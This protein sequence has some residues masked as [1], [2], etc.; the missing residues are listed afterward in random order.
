VNKKLELTRRL[1]TA[2]LA[3]SPAIAQPVAPQAAPQ[4]T[5][6][7]GAAPAGP[8]RRPQPPEPLFIASELDDR[9]RAI[10]LHQ[11][12][13]FPEEPR[14]AVTVTKAPASSWTLRLRIP[15]WSSA[16]AVK[17]NGRVLDATP[18]A[19]SYLC[20]A[21]VWKKGDRVELEMPMSLAAEPFADEP[22]VQAFLY[23]PVVLAGDFGNQGLTD[24]LVN[25]QQGPAVAK[26]PM[27]VPVSQLLRRGD[28]KVFKKY[29]QM[30]LQMKR[31]ALTKLNRKAN[32]KG[33]SG[34]G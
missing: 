11:D 5:P 1:F 9:E 7:A 8:P 19:G 12:T 34:T 4:A 17:V 18:G 13:R 32:E 20:I 30:K 21:R 6:P 10:G 28:A 14:T 22:A 29:S 15:S 25:N 33:S 27:S 26:A 31:E 3:G 23:G 24:A 2:A 16:A